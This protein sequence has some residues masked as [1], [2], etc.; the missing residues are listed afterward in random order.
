MMRWSLYLGRLS[1]IRIYVHWTFLL[2]IAWVLI[3]DLGKRG[4]PEGLTSV[5][6]ILAAFFCIVLHELGHALTARKYG[7]GTKSINLLPIG[8]LAN[9]ERMPKKPVRELNVAIA[10]PLVNFGIAGILYIILLI[11]NGIPSKEELQGIEGVSSQWFLFHLFVVNALLAI[12]NLIPAFPMDGGRIL[13]ALLSFRNSR[14][15]ATRIAAQTGQFL[16][17]LF[18]FVGLFHHFMLVFIGIFIFLG[19]N[20]ENIYVSTSSVL[21]RY[22]VRDVLMHHYITLS[23]YETL[24]K[25]VEHLLD[26]Q[27]TDFL[28][29]E[30]HA[31]RGVLSRGD[32][33]EGLGVHGKEGVVM[34]VMRTDFEK[35]TPDMDLHRIYQR[36]SRGGASVHPVFDEEDKLIGI[37]NKENIQEL[38]MVREILEK[39][40]EEG[41]GPKKPLEGGLEKGSSEA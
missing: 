17:I 2:L 32:I 38:L 26:G 5:G 8:G 37:L 41:E 29:T 13:R 31:V 25:A 9:M 4:F 18:V 15:K 19:A 28:V 3:G 7:I 12:F 23:P 16:A 1:G 27:D 6:F 20:A 35:L 14:Q 33:L 11:S 24:E 22:K 34:K 10:G 39:G 36:I 21:E 30:G 40:K